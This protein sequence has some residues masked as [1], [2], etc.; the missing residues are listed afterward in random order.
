MFICFGESTV[1]DTQR[2]Y[3]VRDFIQKHS[4]GQ[5]IPV[6]FSRFGFDRAF[7]EAKERF[8]QMP[9]LYSISEKSKKI[10]A[11]WQKDGAEE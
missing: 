5:D 9:I 4:E 11:D 6:H 1:A 7:F 8:I 10:I 2:F 3:S